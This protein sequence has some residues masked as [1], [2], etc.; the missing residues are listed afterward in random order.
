MPGQ[1]VQLQFC[2]RCPVCGGKGVLVT[3]LAFMD[4]IVTECEA[5]GGMRY[6]K[7]ALACTYKEK[8]IVELLGLTASQAM[9]IFEDAKIKRRL[10]VMQQVGLSYL[11]LGQPLS[12]LSGG[13]R[14]RIKLA[15][16]LGK[17]EALL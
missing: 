14:Q 13:E 17:R 3:E 15:K 9:E 12:T 11:T 6:N 7:E 8:D 1:P 5:C 4:P 10:G 16:N 2:R